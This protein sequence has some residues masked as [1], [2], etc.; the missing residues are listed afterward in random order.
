[1]SDTQLAPGAISVFAPPLPECGATCAST[2]VH[3]RPL[4]AHVRAM[5]R[6]Y[7]HSVHDLLTGRKN[8]H[9]D[10]AIFGMQ[11]GQPDFEK[12]PIPVM[13]NPTK[14]LLIERIQDYLHDVEGNDGFAGWLAQLGAELFV[15]GYRSGALRIGNKCVRNLELSII[16]PY[17]EIYPERVTVQ[18]RDIALVGRPALHRVLDRR[19]ERFGFH[20]NST[21][22]FR[23]HL[24]EGSR[25]IGILDDHPD[26]EI[27]TR[28]YLRFVHGHVL[29]L[30]AHYRNEPH[31]QYPHILQWLYLAERFTKDAAPGTVPM[32]DVFA[33]FDCMIQDGAVVETIMD[34]PDRKNPTCP[35]YVTQ[36][37]KMILPID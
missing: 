9:H 4:P 34:L 27:L 33:A 12:R 8:C 10:G 32:A 17:Q 26:F 19:I 15:E 20:E 13:K 31:G 18:L 37:A 28:N 36:A 23:G 25:F 35:N 30:D 3:S 29:F 16:V 21:R 14:R 7:G 1:L 24:A 2:T 6:S 22:L 5:A 11:R